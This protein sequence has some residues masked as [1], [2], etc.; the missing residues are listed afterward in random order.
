MVKQIIKVLALVAVA[1]VSGLVGGQLASSYLIGDF[2]LALDNNTIQGPFPVAQKEVIIRENEAIV[3]AIAKV[4]GIA[5]S[6]EVADAKG[7]V[8]RGS[9]VIITSDGMAAVPYGLYPPGSQAK[10]MVGG[11]KVS[12][13]VLKRDK[14]ANIAILKLEGSNRPTA[15]FYSVEDVK[16]GQRVFMVGTLSESNIFANEGIVRTVSASSVGTNIIETPPAAGSPVFDIEGSIIG[17]ALVDNAGFV[18][19]IPI[20]KIKELSGL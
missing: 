6:V 18:S 13:T 3:A 9:G 16:M 4:S 20:A 7:A 15:G 1:L 5:I 12:Y 8:T 11:Q 14:A 10:V 2:S 19:A 17:M